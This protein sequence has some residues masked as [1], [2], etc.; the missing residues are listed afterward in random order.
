MK[1]LLLTAFEPFGGESINPSVE[2][3]RAIRGVH[4]EGAQVET[5]VLPVVRFDAEAAALERI[6]TSKPD[7]VIM[8]GQAANRARVT[9][10][11][12]AINVDDFP[13]PDNDGNLPPCEPIVEDGPVGYFS[14]LSIQSIVAELKTRRIPAAI[15]NS[16]GTYLCNRLFYRVMHC[17]ATEDLRIQAGFIHVPY[18]HEQILDKTLESPSMS[19]DTILE[20]VHVAIEVSLSSCSNAPMK[21]RERE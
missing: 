21:R 1:K 3:A 7:I 16:A 6:R 18:L 2:A 4:F 13:I 8:L 9:P 14:T 5:L 12:V 15:S 11:R 20:A 17:I 19:R 10:E